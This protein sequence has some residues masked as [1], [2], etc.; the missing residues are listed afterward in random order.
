MKMY[1]SFYENNERKG[2][3]KLE[4]SGKGIHTKYIGTIVKNKSNASSFGD[5]YSLSRGLNVSQKCFP[6]VLD[7]NTYFLDVEVT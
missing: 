2:Y 5:D 6:C 4:K 1:I 3:I 7:N